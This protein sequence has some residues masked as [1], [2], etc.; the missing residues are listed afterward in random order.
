MEFYDVWRRR[1][2]PWFRLGCG[3]EASSSTPMNGEDGETREKQFCG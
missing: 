1:A 2:Q 3:T